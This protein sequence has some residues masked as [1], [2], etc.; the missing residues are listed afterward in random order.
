L[1]EVAD[2]IR[3]GNRDYPAGAVSSASNEL[4][5]RVSG[6]LKSPE[7]FANLVTGYRNGSP[8][9]LSDVASVSDAE[10]EASSTALIDGKPGVGMDIRAA[11]GANVVEVADGVKQVIDAMQGACRPARRC[12]SPMTSRPTS[13]SRWPMWKPPCWRGRR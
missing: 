9:R 6:K 3:A 4:N 11:R 1:Q 12:T 13:K 10:A 2:A 7:D 5:V 8:I